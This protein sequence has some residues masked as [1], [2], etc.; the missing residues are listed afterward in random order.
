M[1]QHSVAVVIPTYNEVDNLPTVVEQLLSLPEIKINII[2][3]DDGSPD[4]T[5]RVADE[6]AELHSGKFQVIHRQGKLGLGTAYVEGFKKAMAGGSKYIV[7]M[8]ADLSHPPDLVPVMVN[9]LDEFD[10]AVASRYV[11]GGGLDPKWGFLRRQISYWGG[12]GIRMVLGLK[13]KDPT[14]GFK[15]FRR[16]ALE[17]I[18]PGRLTLTGF[19][20]QSEVAYQCKQA[21]LKVVEQPFTFMDRY[22]GDSKMSVGIMF[23]AFFRLTKLRLL[24]HG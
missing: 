7:Q 3:V 8:D 22:A 1:A 18:D 6:L 17:T 16:S 2:V 24:R 21:G 19:G 23:E 15:A 13:I 12:F 4:G 5:G 11:E 10:V 14:S 20:F 9:D